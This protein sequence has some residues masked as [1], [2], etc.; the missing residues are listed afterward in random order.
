MTKK[1]A[2]IG[3]AFRLPGTTTERCWP[4]FEAGRDL[5]T[6]VD[7]SRWEKS[8]FLHPNKSHPGTTYT[9]AAGSIGDVSTFDAGFFGISPR[10]AAF[11]D[12]QQ[13]I[14]LEMSWEALENSGVTASS[15]RGSNCGV[16]IGIS[17]VDYFFR[18]LDDLAVVDTTSATGLT[19]SIAANRLSYFYDLRGPSV[20]LD[21]ACSSSLVAFH[22]ACQ[23]ILS[24]E[25]RQALAGGINLHLH[26][27]GFVAFAK[28]SMLSKRGRCNVFDASGDGY[29]R[30]EGGGIFFLKDYDAAVADGNRIIAVVAGTAVN[31]DGRKTGLTVPSASAQEA[32]LTQVYAKAGISPD[33]IDYIEAHGTGTAVGDPIETHA[34]GAAIG[35]KRNKSKPLLIGSVKSNLGH[36]ESASGVAGLVKSLMCIQHRR[37]PATIGIKT[38]NPNIKFDEWNLKVATT[39]VP[40]PKTGKLIV[41]INSFGFGGANAHV[42]LESYE[43]PESKVPRLAN[44]PEVPIVITAKSEVALKNAALDMVSYLRD[45]PHTPLYDIA[46][47]ASFDRDWHPHRALVFAKD[48]HAASRDFE[49]FAKLTSSTSN[50]EVVN[51]LA[52]NNACGPAFIFSG[53]GSQWA[54]MGKTLL[55]EDVQ[56]RNAVKEVD[57][58]FKQYADFSLEA[59]L[60]GANNVAGEDRFANTEVAQPALFALQVGIVAMLRHKGITPVA[61]A[62]HSV[63]EVAAAWVSGALTLETAVKVVYHRSRLQGLTKGSGQM[64]AVSLDSHS[65]QSAIEA[66]GESAALAISGFNSLRGITI[67][68]AATALTKLEAHLTVS[69]VAFKRLNLDYAFHSPAMDDIELPIEGA[70]ANIKAAEATTPLYSTVTGEVIDGRELHAT[71][72]WYNIRQPVLFHQAMQN[73]LANGINVFIEIG[74]HAILRGYIKDALL[75][76]EIDGKVITTLNRHQES[77]QRIRHTIAET[78]LSGCIP[79][80]ASL[81]PW[82]GRHVQLPTY[83]WQRERHWVTS[84]ADA[85]QY[86]TR[87]TIHPLL[88]YPLNNRYPDIAWE[89]KIDAALAPNYQDHLIDGALVFPGAAF[90]EIALAAAHA[91]SPADTHHLLEVE[92]LEIRTPLTLSGEHTK[93]LQTT[94]NAASGEMTISARD[95]GSHTSSLHATARVLSHFNSQHPKV[96]PETSRETDYEKSAAAFLA[97]L[98]T[99][100]PDFDAAHHK[101]LTIKAGLT[102]GPAYSAISHGWLIEP[103]ESAVSSTPYSTI[104]ATAHRQAIACLTVPSVIEAEIDQHHLH[105][106][107]LDS[108]FQLVAQLIRDSADVGPGIAYIPVRVERMLVKA[109]AKSDIVGKSHRPY[110]ARATL[111]RQ[112]QQS[113][114]IDFEIFDRTGNVI[115]V[116]DE[117]RFHRIRLQKNSGDHLKFLDYRLIESPH[118]NSPKSPPALAF[119][120]LTQSLQMAFTVPAAATSDEA[121]NEV[122]LTEVEPLLDELCRAYVYAAL[123]IIA[124]ANGV[125]TKSSLMAFINRISHDNDADA[126]TGTSA[127]NNTALKSA[128]SNFINQVSDD[129]DSTDLPSNNVTSIKSAAQQK[130]LWASVVNYAL[131][132]QLLVNQADT[133]PTPLELTASA[134]STPTDESWQLVDSPE[135]SATPQDIWHCLASEYPDYFELTKEVGRF[136]YHLD[137]AARGDT[138]SAAA[139]L[140]MQNTSIG[141]AFRTTLATSGTLSILLSYLY[142]HA[143]LNKVAKALAEQIK[144]AKSNR[145][146]N[147]SPNTARQIRIAEI[148]VAPCLLPVLF[149]HAVA[150]DSAFTFLSLD[151]ALENTHLQA[152]FPRLRIESVSDSTGLSKATHDLIIISLDSIDAA[153]LDIQAI[154]NHAKNRLAD[155]GVLLVLTNHATAWQALM[156]PSP[157]KF[158]LIQTDNA[159]QLP[160]CT[161]LNQASLHAA[162]F[163]RVNALNL[164]TSTHLAPTCAPQVLVCQATPQAVSNIKTIDAKPT[165]QVIVLIVDAENRYDWKNALDKVMTDSAQ[166]A[167][168]IEYVEDDPGNTI[169]SFINAQFN[170]HGHIDAIVQLAGLSLSIDG[171]AARQNAAFTSLAPQIKR[172]DTAARIVEAAV[173]L[174]SPPTCWVVTSGATDGVAGMKHAALLKS[175]LSTISD[176]TLWGWCRTLINEAASVPIKLIDLDEVASLHITA[177]QLVREISAPTLESEIV[178]NAS[179]RY[180]TRLALQDAPS[181]SQITAKNQHLSQAT[182]PSD[183]PNLRLGF[184]QPGQLKNLRWELIANC[185]PQNDDV[186]IEVM[187]TGLNFRD[188]MYALGIL[189][190]AAVENGFAGASLGL[191]FA[192]VVKSVG[193]N[194]T[195]VMPG[196]RVVGFGAA[197]F[198]R[199]LVTPANCVS[200]IP[201]AANAMS[202]ASA[203][204]IPSTFFT[205][206]YSLVHLARLDKNE[207]VLIHGAAGGVGLAAIQ[208]ARL[209]GAVVYAT[210]GSDE[211]RDVLRL[212][213]V[214]HIYDSRTLTF[215][216]EILRD[217]NGEGVDVVLNSLAGE[218]I[219]RNFRVLKSFGRFIEL[220]KR[221]FYENTKVGLRPFRN[222]IS[223][224]GVDA[225][226]LMLEQPQLTQRLFAEIMALFADQTLHPLPHTVFDAANV[227][228]AFRYMQQAKQIGKV[229][230]SHQHGVPTEYVDIAKQQITLQLNANATYLVTGGLR[231][232]GLKTAEWL[233]TKGAKNLVLVSRSGSSSS[234]PESA[235]AVARLM[236]AGVRV[237]A[238]A[239]DISDHAATA[240]LINS[241]AANMPPLRG[242]FHAAMVIDDGL[243]STLSAEKMH[244]VFAPKILGAANLHALT[245]NITLDLFVLFSSATTLFGNPGQG[246]YVAANAWLEAFAQMRIHSGLNA[247][248]VRWGAIDDAGFLARNEN[249][250]AALQKRM[251]GN[252]ISSETALNALEQMLLTNTSGFGV[253]ELDWRTLARSL[254]T[255]DSPKY[256]LIAKACGQLRLSDTNEQD[257]RQMARDLSQSALVEAFIELVRAEVAEIL[258]MSPEKVDVNRS[259]FDMGL[260]S[261]MGVEVASALE[262]RFGVRLSA[263]ILSENPI[264]AKLAARLADMVKQTEQSHDAPTKPDDSAMQL[265]ELVKLANQHGMQGSD[266][267]LIEALKQQLEQ[268]AASLDR[269]KQ[270]IIQ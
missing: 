253:M 266:Q 196:D 165:A 170:V 43:S 260:D 164:V 149:C 9:F 42:I 125:M 161:A 14:L 38:L 202:F 236:E 22:Q 66:V 169:M 184:Q 63:G 205:A 141:G 55:T 17:S 263:M 54:G 223:Y 208:I 18:V 192:G 124:D 175:S 256:A 82:R 212:M 111:V 218:A 91:A 105:P 219:N 146:P 133:S 206:Y 37:V 261:L 61:V 246:N 139:L 243:A 193:A 126:S 29:V 80:W 199:R 234:S 239:C 154:L 57:R 121:G 123:K 242:I 220:G 108:T 224:F 160:A 25:S 269:P 232:F 230:V 173:S 6:E 268:N 24:G 177:S 221:D 32:L 262:N 138:H 166:T 227:V 33:S 109:S 235:L 209:T 117:V 27:A 65:A 171:D 112:S 215:A 95:H 188:V 81:P 216:D 70:L 15:I 13:R 47:S 251:G 87:K 73:M 201:D 46:Y 104:S 210:A 62:G 4:D 134:T 60:A 132:Q 115:A 264:I 179:C 99:R 163:I 128:L 250:K 122:F 48:S 237:E 240:N 116:L 190:D 194:V 143:G 36:L 69:R 67:A 94:L 178:Y 211:K 83:P 180:V 187:A 156:Y 8:N 97:S 182:S 5:V 101:R 162:G 74:P 181:N 183:I 127:D 49:Q 214:T 191:E 217:T 72:W 159:T 152:R 113:L 213:G 20:A 88:G 7:P 231:G 40:L 1:V 249:V 145:A 147:F 34:L 44:I 102:F 106:G 225:D 238:L 58:I 26:P 244:A 52:V 195:N 207:R 245:S 186:E 130:S 252:A 259:L 59:E 140:K 254:P 31:T 167:H 96:L 110:A 204:T 257:V 158:S 12:P 155:G 265:N 131:R 30:S 84:S 90:A 222:N 56:F 86:L 45:H 107:I 241:I 35:M 68:G 16:F 233:A 100:A 151:P 85:A 50:V 136:G 185:V 75:E 79:T 228:A 93:V 172:C 200:R 255:S 92:S 174:K 198:S 103:G 28:A 176:A 98:P 189:T 53:N 39:N 153:R 258:R 3:Y 203:A 142:S 144:N 23:S 229:I 135:D 2:I 197:C 118:P 248:V 114:S 247:T 10:E 120:A 226:Q 267:E 150:D 71:Y 119:E 76:A 19:T 64:T 148:A 168:I 78:I 21:T 137:A 11:M 129:I 157:E 77:P 51:A 89:K 41:G 270:R